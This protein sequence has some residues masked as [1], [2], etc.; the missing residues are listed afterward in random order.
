MA[1]VDEA[2]ARSG[3]AFLEQLKQKGHATL[4]QSP[5]YLNESVIIEGQEFDRTLWVDRIEG[6]RLKVVLQFSTKPILGI[7]STTAAGFIIGRSGDI[8]D[9]SPD[10]ALREL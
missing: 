5:P 10:E 8:H 6:D 7:C 3:L 4:A 1:E 2:V 9:L